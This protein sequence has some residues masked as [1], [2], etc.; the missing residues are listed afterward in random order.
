MTSRLLKHSATRL[1]GICAVVG[2][3]VL[4]VDHYLHAPQDVRDTLNQPDEISTVLVET[5][6]PIGKKVTTTDG[7]C[8]IQVTSITGTLAKLTVTTRHGDTHRF[9]KA[10]GG[11]RLVVPTP[12]ALYY[13]DL[14]RIRGNRVDLAVS[15]RG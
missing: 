7:V 10:I 12:T 1:L 5:G 11:H 6:I 9:D 14:V 15:K 4:V 3:G 8:T 13:V 2:A